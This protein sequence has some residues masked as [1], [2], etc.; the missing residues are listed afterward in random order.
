M[1]VMKIGGSSVGDATRIRSVVEIVRKELPR[2]PAVVCSAHKGVTN[3]LF[4]TAEE[5]LAGKPSISTVVA[6]HERIQKELGVPVETTTAL[7]AELDVLLKGI[8]M[9]KELTPRTMDYVASFG[10]RLSCR[11]IAAFF[12]K[13]GI[14]AE[15]KDAFDVGLVTD[16]RFGGA[17]PLPEADALMKSK[18]TALTKLPIVTGYIGKTK[19]GDITTLGRNG[20]DYSATIVGAGID[21]EEVQI[22]TDVD[23]VM[24]AD[25]SVVPQAK[26]LDVMSFDEAGELAY[27]GGRVLHPSTLVPAVHKRIP[28]RV[29]NTF[30]PESKGT[31][32]LAETDGKGPKSIVYKENQFVVSVTSARMLM[33]HGF[34]SRI[35]EICARHRIVIDMVST[36]EVSVSMTTD[37]RRNLD[38]AVAELKTFAEVGIEEGKAIVCVVGHGMRETPGIAADVFGALKREGINVEMI[39]QGASKINIAFVIDDEDIKKAV[40][41]LHKQFFE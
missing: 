40:L 4:K 31:V 8:A 9:L 36:S 21:A 29:L 5:A 15:A 38:D 11:T 33:G 34:L 19:Q 30:R 37:R 25:P 26:M 6:T 13:S 1:I 2:K 24:T 7:L 35:F 23:G 16:A 14:P 32:I 22:W 3:L 12:T 18:I 28:V 10:E 27:Y 39:S 20:S 17:Q 41:A